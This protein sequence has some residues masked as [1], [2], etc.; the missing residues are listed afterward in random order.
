[1]IA[2][3]AA[4]ALSACGGSPTP[5]VLTQSDIPSYL[6][7]KLNRSAS[8][9]QARQT[10]TPPCNTDRVAVFTVPGQRINEQ[11]LAPATAPQVTSASLACPNASTLDVAYRTTA[12]GLA[13]LY[14]SGRAVSGVG[15]GAKLFDVGRVAP[16]T[17][18]EARLYLPGKVSMARAYL[19]IW[20][21]HDHAQV[22]LVS[23][24]SGD[25]RITAALAELLARRVA[26][27]S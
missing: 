10:R 6:G 12:T 4:V 22:V 9:S 24:P 26:A 23:G 27:R 16:A 8:A 15:D 21:E 14:G 5:G 2:F 18:G 11:A 13:S 1:M 19:V 25:K 20:R 17:A 3:T 7:V